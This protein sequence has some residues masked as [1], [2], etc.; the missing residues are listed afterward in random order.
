MALLAPKNSSPWLISQAR[1]ECE[2]LRTRQ[3]TLPYIVIPGENLSTVSEFADQKRYITMLL[4]D[5]SPVQ[6]NTLEG[7][8]QRCCKIISKP[9]RRISGKGAGMQGTDNWRNAG[10]YHAVRSLELLLISWA[11]F[12]G[13]RWTI[14][15]SGSREGVQGIQSERSKG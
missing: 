13:S 15:G 3:L 11:R 6:W 5:C 8:D 2:L 1:K 14:K 9:P 4:Y 12:E 10:A 7:M